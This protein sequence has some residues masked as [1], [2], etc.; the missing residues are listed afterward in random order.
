MVEV[1]DGPDPAVVHVVGVFV[2]GVVVAVVA[3]VVEAVVVVADV[4]VVAGSS[5]SIPT[6]KE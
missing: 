5:G 3:I 6:R 1:V 2:V 4:V